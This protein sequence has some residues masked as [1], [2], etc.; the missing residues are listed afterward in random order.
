MVSQF[1]EVVE[2]PMMVEHHDFDWRKKENRKAKL[3]ERERETKLLSFFCLPTNL[4][5][6]SASIMA[7]V[8]S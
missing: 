6:F 8:Y 3:K 7:F 2:I 5:I 1:I 4:H